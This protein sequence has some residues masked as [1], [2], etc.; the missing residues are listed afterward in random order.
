MAFKAM[1]RVRVVKVPQVRFIRS[2]GRAVARGARRGLSVAG[3]AAMSEK[4]TF[5]AVGAAAA[6]GAAKKFGVD[7]PKVDALGTAGTY[8]LVAW[9]AGKYMRSTMLQHVA[10]GLL[11]VGAYELCSGQGLAGDSG[12]M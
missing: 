8:G 3:R 9:M 10:T 4:H 6:L 1:Q 12:D 2:G 7:L 5:A 11:C